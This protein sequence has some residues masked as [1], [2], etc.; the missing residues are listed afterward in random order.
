M[1]NL[2]KCFIFRNFPFHRNDLLWNVRAKHTLVV[3]A[4]PTDHRVVR[5]RTACDT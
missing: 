1:N 2:F 5:R 3:Q 4:S